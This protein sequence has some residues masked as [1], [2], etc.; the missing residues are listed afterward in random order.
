MQ[1]PSLIRAFSPTYAIALLFSPDNL[2]GIFI[3]G[4]VFLSTTGAEALYSDMGHVGKQNIYA[5]WPYVK[6][7]LLLNYLGQAAWILS[8]MG[9]EAYAD[10]EGLNP[11]YMMAPGNFQLSL[12]ILATLAAII[13]SQSLITGSYTLVS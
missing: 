8:A 9:N 7:C 3:L 13:A 5:T 1:N 10:I 2:S 4:A 11:F 12:V 6:A